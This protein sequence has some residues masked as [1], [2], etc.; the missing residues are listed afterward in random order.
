MNS[1]IQDVKSIALSGTDVITVAPPETGVLSEYFDVQVAV[2]Y[3][4]VAGTSG[5]TASFQISPDGGTTWQAAAL[6]SITMAPAANVM[7]V[8][9]ARIYL[10]G[11]KKMDTI[12]ITAIKVTLT[13]LDATNAVVAAVAT[14]SP[15]V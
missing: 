9:N 8:G 5:V 7:G 4:A 3:A 2:K 12:P 10:R 6:P 11:V 15:L 14:E 1:V 13:N